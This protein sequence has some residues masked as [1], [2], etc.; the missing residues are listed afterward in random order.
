M[1]FGYALELSDRDSWN[2]DLLDTDIPS[3]LFVSIMSSRRLQ[4]NA[5]DV[6][7]MS[8]RQQMFVGL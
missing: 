3:V 4:C 8:S 2:I 7:K 1:H 5:E 6:M